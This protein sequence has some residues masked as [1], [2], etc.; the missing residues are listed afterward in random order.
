MIGAAVLIAVMGGALF[1]AARNT[2][3]EEST[4]V[5]PAPD[6]RVMGG[7]VVPSDA[8]APAEALAADPAPAIFPAPPRFDV[9]RIAAD[10]GVLVAGQATAGAGLDVLL[11]SDSV[12][13]TMVDPQGNFVALFDIAPSDSARMMTLA[14]RL[15]D[16]TRVMSDDS[17]LVAPTPAPLDLAQTAVAED[18]P[19]ELSSNDTASIESAS[20]D[21][22]AT[23]LTMNDAGT[24]ADTD[25][26]TDA[27]S[28]DGRTDDQTAA[29]QIA[30]DASVTQTI[31]DD[32]RRDDPTST[33]QLTSRSDTSREAAP[34]IMPAPQAMTAPSAGSDAVAATDQP[35]SSAADTVASR[36][37]IDAPALGDLASALSGDGSIDTAGLQSDLP[38]APQVTDADTAPAAR[39]DAPAPPP[40]APDAPDGARAA[41]PAEDT[42]PPVVAM[43][44]PARDAAPEQSDA[45]GAPDA[46][47]A[48]GAAP[49][50]LAPPAVLIGRDGDI[51]MLGQ[52]NVP[53]IP[54]V[55]DNIRIDAISY[56]ARGDVRLVGQSPQPE[57]GVRVYLDNQFVS[58]TRSLA[59][60][61]WR[62]VLPDVDTGVY[63]LRVD[64]VDAQG[65]VSSRFETPFQREEPALLGAD[66]PDA[67]ADTTPTVQALTVQPGNTLW[68]IS[69]QTYGD[70]FLYVRI[71]EANRSQIRDPDLI[72]PG[73]VFTL[74]Q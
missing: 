56:D 59:D 57:D 26:G 21:T 24:D 18:A 4:A 32:T 11:D 16:G 34:Q 65:Q 39:A 54:E 12:A 73:Q 58:D 17:V 69:S 63:T 27:G 74:P 51:R 28:D 42:A 1:F 68:G 3:V 35:G 7:G 62:I 48:S 60:R 13:Q 10:G 45:A 72:Y 47:A 19:A 22:E 5:A 52:A 53:T 30:A 20:N 43:A 70:G 61:S 49:Q 40:A 64:A 33:A 71:F 55:M 6:A 67:G 25:D 36:Q 66:A 29:D 23:E 8:A 15:A 38:A 44:A 50:P 14:M 37:N 9:V 46:A 31:A 41:A 2:G